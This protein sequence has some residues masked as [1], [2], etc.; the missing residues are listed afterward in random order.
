MFQCCYSVL[1]YP[2]LLQLYE[3]CIYETRIILVIRP[4]HLGD[5]GS[6]FIHHLSKMIAV[7]FEGCNI[8]TMIYGG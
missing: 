7:K 6:T 5:I 1:V 4:S 3:F 2:F 8:E